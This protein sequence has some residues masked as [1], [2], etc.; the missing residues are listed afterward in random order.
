MEYI[1]LEERLM[2]SLDLMRLLIQNPTEEL[3]TKCKYFI[4][5]N[6]P[7]QEP[8][9]YIMTDFKEDFNYDC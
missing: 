2:Q 4:E 1:E 3:I 5:E 9:F 6:A 7:I 8:K